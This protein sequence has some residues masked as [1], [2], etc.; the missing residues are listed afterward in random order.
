L[1]REYRQRLGSDR[2]STG[3]E[4]VL[5]DAI[6]WL[7][8]NPHLVVEVAGHTDSNGGATANLALSGRRANTVRDYLI[9]GGV[10][11]SQLTARSYGESETVAD[12]SA[13][14][15]RAENRRVEPRILNSRQ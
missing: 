4:K 5:D 14:E 10:S 6:E 15:G 2:P 11:A 12:N 13:I 9:D 3:A 7:E 8:R 1:G